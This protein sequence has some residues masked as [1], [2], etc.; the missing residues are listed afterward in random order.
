MHANDGMGQKKTMPKS[1]IYGL[2]KKNGHKS[3]KVHW[4]ISSEVGWRKKK[5]RVSWSN[6]LKGFSDFRAKYFVLFTIYTFI[7]TADS[8]YYDL[9]YAIR[10]LCFFP[11]RTIALY[12]RIFS[13]CL[14]RTPNTIIHPWSQTQSGAS[15]TSGTSG[16]RTD[17]MNQINT[18]TQLNA[19][20]KCDRHFVEK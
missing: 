20:W 1:W 2:K 16:T 9:L 4:S 18:K 17:S 6:K 13:L 15:G 8:Y 14:S 19:N 3:Q 7:L 12:F 11:W 10:L 5:R